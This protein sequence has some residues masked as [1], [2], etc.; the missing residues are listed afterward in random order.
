MNGEGRR[1]WKEKREEEEGKGWLP[2][3]EE[4]G[5]GGSR[6][7]RNISESQQEATKDLLVFLTFLSNEKNHH[8]YREANRK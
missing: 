5:E 7:R 6:E 3:Q 2:R 4:M 8:P 1:K